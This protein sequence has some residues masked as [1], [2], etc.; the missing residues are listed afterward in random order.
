MRGRRGMCS[1]DKKTLKRQNG[2]VPA[3][4]DVRF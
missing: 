2:N 3:D 4:K 1:D